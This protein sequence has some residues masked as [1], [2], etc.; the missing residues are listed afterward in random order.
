MS[1]SGIGESGKVVADSTRVGIAVLC[2]FGVAWTVVLLPLS[3]ASTPVAV[4][5]MG[6]A[7]LWAGS[8]LW[9]R[10][11]LVIDSGGG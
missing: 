4:A 2:M 5:A 7:I 1:S 9:A 11:C 6:G 3:S 8:L 10:A